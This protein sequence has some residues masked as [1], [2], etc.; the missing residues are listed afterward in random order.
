MNIS[1]ISTIS[2][3]NTLPSVGK[4]RTDNPFSKPGS[5]TCSKLGSESGKPYDQHKATVPDMRLTH[6]ARKG[7]D[8]NSCFI[9]DP[10]SENT[11]RP[12]QEDNKNS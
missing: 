7:H 1:P 4:I 2:T 3:I 8:Q 12:L 9:S 11:L 10:I 6:V 5:A